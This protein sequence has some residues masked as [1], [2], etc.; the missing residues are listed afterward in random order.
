MFANDLFAG[1]KI[2]VSGGGAGLGK[3]QTRSV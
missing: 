3:A 2:C 1:R